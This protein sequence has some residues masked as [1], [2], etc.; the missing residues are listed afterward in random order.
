LLASEVVEGYTQGF[1]QKD[2][3]YDA[4]N[5]LVIANSDFKALEGELKK[6]AGTNWDIFCRR[7]RG[8]KE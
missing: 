7:L 5:K 1:L 8:Y 6:Q 2:F 3:T 4:V